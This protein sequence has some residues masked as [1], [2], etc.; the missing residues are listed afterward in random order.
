MENKVAL[1]SGAVVVARNPGTVVSV[2]AERIIVRRDKKYSTRL[3]PLDT[4]DVDNYKLTKFPAPT[5]TA[6]STSDPWSK[7]A[8]RSRLASPWPMVLLR[9]GATWH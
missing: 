8:T 6:A 3:T 1:D 2:D 9:I 5:K 7:S 4:A